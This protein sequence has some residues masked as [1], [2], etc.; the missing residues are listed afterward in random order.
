MAS[1]HRADK[2]EEFA[3]APTF[4]LIVKYSIPTIIGMLVNALYV[5]IDRIFV[6]HLAGIGELGMAGINI[7]MPVTTIVFAVAMFAGAGAGANISLSLGRGERDKAEQYIG[8]GLVMGAAMAFALTVLFILF[9]TP[10]LQLFGASGEAIDALPYAEQYLTV[11]LVGTTIN[12]VGFCLSRFVL[13]Q[14][15]TTVSM[16]SQILGVAVNIVLAPLF[17]FV[18]HWGVTGSA[19]ATVVAQTCSM[20][21]T[22][23]Y[24]LRKRMPLSIHLKHLKPDWG[25]IGRIAS[26]GIS[27]GSLQ[28]AMAFVQIMLNNSLAPY[29]VVATSALSVVNAVSS[30]LLMPIFGINQG[31]QPIMGFNYGARHYQ[32][33]RRLL[34]QSIAIAVCLMTAFWALLMLGAEQVVLL[35]GAQNEGLIQLG[36]KA[37]RMYLAALPLVG[38]QVISANYFQSVGKAGYSFV[39]TQSRQVL[40]LLPMVLILPHFFGMN[41]V[42]M[43]GAIADGASA[44]LTGIFLMIELKK[45][46]AQA[47][48][49]LHAAAL[50]TQNNSF[51]EAGD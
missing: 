4:G 32:R 21:F 35:F 30:V 42:F 25:A 3:S 17:L 11:M 51:E 16:A 10:V 8:N 38:F 13:A 19:W 18:F 50:A 34:L 46:D 29:G 12:T 37:I 22:L 2:S 23:L 14:G 49:E 47:K 33:V 15:Y 26:I 39:L 43:S 41:G 40:I 5:L 6:G 27:P 31:A 45:L 48:Y 7:A 36:P 24:F 28:L 9:R 1:P 44:V 20:L